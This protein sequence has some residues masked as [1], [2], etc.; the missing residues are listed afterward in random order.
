ML[1]YS[2]SKE[3]SYLTHLFNTP[4]ERLFKKVCL[5]NYLVLISQIYRYSDAISKYEAVMKAE[6]NVPQLLLNAKE[7]TCH[8]LSKVRVS[9]LTTR[10]CCLLQ[11]TLH[12]CEIYLNGVNMVCSFF[13][14]GPANC[15]SHISMQRSSEL[16]SSQ[17]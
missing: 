6:P 3:L 14:T 7:R 5:K 15:Q 12:S 2:L 9:S 11:L 10:W 13:F 16:R 4:L 17:R 1:P 8:C